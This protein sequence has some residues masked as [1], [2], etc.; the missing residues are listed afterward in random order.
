M[1]CC[2]GNSVS[3]IDSINARSDKAMQS[4]NTN[5]VQFLTFFETEK[6][7]TLLKE[8]LNQDMRQLNEK[9]SKKSDM[10]Y[11]IKKAKLANF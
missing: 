1:S 4:A 5:L 11:D 9:I 8:K 7:I 3:N 10:Q 2:S 6:E